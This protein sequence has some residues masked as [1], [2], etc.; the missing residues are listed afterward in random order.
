[1]SG[2]YN[3]IVN[4]DYYGTWVCRREDPVRGIYDA[5]ARTVQFRARMLH[6]EE[7]SALSSESF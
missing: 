4:Q 1:M 6:P 2:N 5:Q 3:D 7:S